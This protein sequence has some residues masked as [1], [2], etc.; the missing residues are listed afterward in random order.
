MNF[1]FLYPSFPPPENGASNVVSH[2]LAYSLP[3]T[4][5]LAFIFMF[6]SDFFIK[7]V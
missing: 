3:K 4:S 1:K 2:P 5:S 6:T 7:P